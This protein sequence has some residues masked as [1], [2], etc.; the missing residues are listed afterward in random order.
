MPGNIISLESVCDENGNSSSWWV[1]FYN[2]SDN[3]YQQVR[4]LWSKGTIRQI[5]SVYNEEILAV[6][7]CYYE[8]EHSES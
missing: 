1:G 2:T 3:Q 8:E 6:L 4:L 5:K 7:G